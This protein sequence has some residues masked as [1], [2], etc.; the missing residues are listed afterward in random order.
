MGKIWESFFVL[1]I[2]E[3]HFGKLVDMALLLL[4]RVV[5]VKVRVARLKVDVDAHLA[6]V[7]IVDV[8]G[9]DAAR[10]EGEEQDEGPLHLSEPR[11]CS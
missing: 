5:V 3:L 10:G 8:V 11:Q 9:H 6:R 7:G 2:G 1:R 4:L